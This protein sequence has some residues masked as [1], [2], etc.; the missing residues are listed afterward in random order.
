MML[1]VDKIIEIVR[2]TRKFSAPYFGKVEIKSHKGDKGFDVVTRVD[3]DIEKFLKSELKNIMPNVSFVGEEFGGDRNKSTFWLVDPLDG[4]GCFVRGLPYCTTMLALI[5]EEK[6]AFSIIYDFVNDDIYHAELGKGAYRNGK[7]IF[8]SDR[9][10]KRAY[11]VCETNTST[12][13]Q[14]V[15]LLLSLREESTLI[16]HCASGYDFML[17]ATGRIDGRLVCDGYGKDYDFAPGTLLVSEAGGVVRNF[18]S[19][20][21][22]YRNLDFIACNPVVYRDLLENK[23]FDGSFFKKTFH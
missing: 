19:D 4:T 6:V 16:H 5:S 17:I 10:L 14:N 23:N 7:R 13:Q 8:V 21:Y 2:S 3:D 11:L 12:S 1:L 9:P 18:N 22:N 20:S 15:N